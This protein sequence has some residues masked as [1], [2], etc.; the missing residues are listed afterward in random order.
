[1]GECSIQTSGEK[2][3][4][5]GKQEGQALPGESGLLG[6]DLPALAGSAKRQRLASH[7]RACQPENFKG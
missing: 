6:D 3:E 2:Q 7:V 4:G 1:M 5:Q